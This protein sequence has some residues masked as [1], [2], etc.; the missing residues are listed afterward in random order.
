[1]YN[2]TP[3]NLPYQPQ[4]L[5]L[6]WNTFF[7]AGFFCTLIVHTLDTG[8]TASIKQ[9]L[10]ELAALTPDAI[11]ELQIGL[12][13]PLDRINHIV[14]EP[15]LLWEQSL[16]DPTIT[17]V[18][19]DTQAAIAMYQGELWLRW[20]LPR[21]EYIQACTSVEKLVYT[22]MVVLEEILHLRQYI[23][24]SRR[25]ILNLRTELEFGEPVNNL[26]PDV[27]ELLELLLEADVALCMQNYLTF[28]EYGHLQWYQD[29]VQAGPHDKHRLLDPVGLVGIF[30]LVSKIYSEFNSGEE[31]ARSVVE[32]IMQWGDWNPKAIEQI[33]AF[34]LTIKAE[35]G[36]S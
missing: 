12:S 27:R 36:H 21:V 7:A 30:M 28:D 14:R 9:H 35:L 11:R 6:N 20:N 32:G 5:D 22:A 31:F 24:P 1:V 19:T 23:T 33:H 3:D 29:R 4:S 15:D 26:D 2:L 25:Y 8:D 34:L 16:V 13:I 17:K 18:Q 10:A